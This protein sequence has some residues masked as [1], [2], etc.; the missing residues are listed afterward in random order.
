MALGGAIATLLTSTLV[1][2]NLYQVQY[3]FDGLTD[4]SLD[5]M[6]PDVWL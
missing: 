1:G 4:E 3:S 2:V 6:I 5:R